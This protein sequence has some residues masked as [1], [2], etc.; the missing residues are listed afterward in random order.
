MFWR[1]KVFEISTPPS[2]FILKEKIAFLLLLDVIDRFDLLNEFLTLDQNHGKKQN[3]RKVGCSKSI[4]R[5]SIEPSI[6]SCNSSSVSNDFGRASI[7]LL[8]IAD[9]SISRASKTC[10]AVS[11]S[12]FLTFISA[13][14]L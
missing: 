3:Y 9:R 11:P 5:H 8:S 14:L 13:L 12:R 2:K 1:D 10:T 4:R 6:V 7:G